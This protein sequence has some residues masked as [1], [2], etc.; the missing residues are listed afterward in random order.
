MLAFVDEVVGFNQTW[1]KK[2][3]EYLIYIKA[4]LLCC[5]IAL[6]EFN[7]KLVY[8]GIGT[9]IKVDQQYLMVAYGIVATHT[10]YRIEPTVHSRSRNQHA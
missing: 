10:P 3:W 5:L 9:N 1:N 8:A 2:R 4:G 7:K 6:F